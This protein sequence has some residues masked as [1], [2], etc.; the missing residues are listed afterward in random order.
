[1][2]NALKSQENL[3]AK[4]K[5]IYIYGPCQLSNLDF[6]SLPRL[7]LW[8]D[9]FVF[10]PGNLLTFPKRWLH[11]EAVGHLTDEWRE[12]MEFMVPCVYYPSLKQQCMASDFDQ[13]P[14]LQQFLCVENV[15]N[16]WDVV[17]QIRT[18]SHRKNDIA[19]VFGKRKHICIIFIYWRVIYR[20][21]SK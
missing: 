18:S 3:K 9:V 2:V 12:V 14:Q 20:F 13:T 16:L 10:S 19:E 4:T 5:D 6:V 21:L 1:M 11:R 8:V 17:G 15:W 7:F